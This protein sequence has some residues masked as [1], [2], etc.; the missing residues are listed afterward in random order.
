MPFKKADPNIVQFA[1][2]VE[3]VVDFESAGRLDGQSKICNWLWNQLKDQVDSRMAELRLMDWLGIDDEAATKKLLSEVYSE[4]GLRN[5]VPVMKDKHP[6]LRCVHSSPLKNVAL[7]MAK[8]ITAHRKSKNGERS[9]PEVGWIKYRA[10]AKNWTSLEYDE[11]N[12][13]WD[14]SQ[15]GWLKLSFGSDREGKRLSLRLKMVK[16]PKH[17][18]NAR[19]CRIVRDGK[20]RYFAVFTF[21]AKKKEQQRALRTVYIDPNLKNFG[22]A[23]DAEGKAFEIANLERLR[24]VERSLDALKRR[25]DKKCLKKSL[26]VDTVHADGT[27][28]TYWRPSRGWTKMNKVIS[29]LEI[30]VREQRKHYQYSLANQLF[31]LYDVV[32]IGDY[33]PENED[34]GKGR[35]YNRAVRNRSMHGSFKDTLSWVAKR[36]GKRAIV[37]D[38]TGTT[39]TCHVCNHVVEGGIHPSIREWDCKECGT[40][41]HRDEN[42]CQNGLRKLL[43]SLGAGAD[44][45]Q[46]PCSGPVQIVGRCDWRFYPQGWQG[47]PHVG[48]ANVNSMR[49]PE[50]RQRGSR[51]SPTRGGDRAPRSS[52]TAPKAMR[53]FA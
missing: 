19:T 1:R 44:S 29:R 37:Q 12:K 5:L 39:R 16:P 48:C 40:H 23:L 34:H 4:I 17:I 42:A 3:L 6:F 28:S 20:G 47:T 52:E 24:E 53:R 22:Y 26:W 8:A 43:A 50:Y 13:G 49:L 9:G 51:T 32:G 7:R 38:E 25:R 36:S 27:V 21:K 41:H 31:R 15:F 35:K 14:V 33:V 2:K 11:P 45:P 18:A 10:W 46:M 30:K